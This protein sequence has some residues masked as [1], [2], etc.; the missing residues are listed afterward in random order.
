MSHNKTAHHES[1]IKRIAC[2]VRKIAGR[3]YFIQ[4][5][6]LHY[7]KNEITHAVSETANFRVIE[8]RRS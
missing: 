3:S 8:H 1:I 2:Y 6:K 5:I 7:G 4:R